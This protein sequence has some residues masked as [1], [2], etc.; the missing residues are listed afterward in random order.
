MYFGMSCLK[1]KKLLQY[2]DHVSLRS[3]C[4]THPRSITERVRRT[5]IRERIRKL[6]DLVPNMDKQTN[7]ADMLVLAVDYIKELQKQAEELSDHHAK[8]IRPHKRKL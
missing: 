2:Q 7:T 8:C 1:W 4:T 6:Q 5:Q 3:R